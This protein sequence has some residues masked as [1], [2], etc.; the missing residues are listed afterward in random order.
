[1][2]GEKQA[3]PSSRSSQTS[4]QTAVRSP[5]GQA[6][7]G[8]QDALAR[9]RRR[10]DQTR[11][12]LVIERIT[13]AFWPV[14]SIAFLAFALIRLELIGILPE[15]LRLLVLLALVAGFGWAAVRGV[16]SFRW[17]G[18]G[19]AVRRLDDELPG[20][21][22]SSL[23][24]RQELGQDDPAA[25]AVWQIHM[26][27]IAA[28]ADRARARFPDI[29]LTARDPRALRYGALVLFLAALVFGQGSVREQLDPRAVLPPA[30]ADETGPVLEAWASPPAYTGRPVVY[31]SELDANSLEVPVGSTV[32]LRLYGGSEAPALEEAVSGGASPAALTGEP[33]LAEA[34][35]TVTRN[36]QVTISDEGTTLGDWAFT[37]T[38]DAP[39]V[40][41]LVEP[42]ERTSEGAA[43]FVYSGADDYG[44][45]AAF[46]R[47]TLDLERIERAHGLVA[48]PEARE[49]IEFDLALPRTGVAKDFEEREIIDLSEHPWAGL[50][51]KVVLHARDAAGQ[52]TVSEP[53]EVVLPGRRFY[54]PLARALVE[55]RRDLLWSLEN[56]TRVSQ[57]LK[58]ITH[59]PDD[60]FDNTKAYLATR[61]AI[62]RLDYAREGNAVAERRPE[63]SDMLWHAAL[64]VEDGDLS[65]ALERLRRAQDRLSQALE[66]PDS[67][68]EEIAGLMEEMQQ[69]MQDYLQEMMRQ[70][71]QN[72]EQNPQDQDQA[73]A[74]PNMSMQDL[75]EMLDRMNEMMQ[76]GQRAEAQELLQ[77]L[78]RLMEN[79]Q[80]TM[81]NGQPQPG[82]GEQMMQGLQDLM[83][84]QQ[85][86]GDQ[87]FEELQ[88][89]FGQQGQLGQQGQQG[90]QG[91]EGQQGQ[92]QQQ[93][94]GSGALG[95]Q[96]EA[97]RQLLEELRRGMPQGGMPG[98]NGQ[99]PG[100][101]ARRSLEQA[102]R[103]MG[104]ARDSLEN[105]D[106]GSAVDDQA[107]ALDNLREGMR[108][109]D[110]AMR[111]QA[112]NQPGSPGGP[113]RAENAPGEPRDPLGRPTG[114]QGDIEGNDVQI[115]GTEAWK[116]SRQ[117]QDEI[118][119]RA[120][121]QDR[122]EPELDYLRRLLDRF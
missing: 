15:W 101:Q 26:A 36:G 40:I 62:R 19:D 68:D 87:T 88:R 69:A 66:D 37:V 4:G 41:A 8:A 121:E 97:L 76:N 28:Q 39:P 17:P 45:T 108:S 14:W 119:R 57:L 54:E 12:A 114:S 53:Y 92:G 2:K 110:E 31:L 95:R 29:N 109:L 91:Q 103:D 48:E 83:R 77:Q 112:Q 13:Q 56:T 65:S 16:R 34:E 24:D 59:R 1:M 10:I 90:Q 32:T 115:P 33:G 9:L 96:Q 63:V 30:A 38:P 23:G 102:E 71:L 22:V 85:E 52:E 107:Q 104:S 18:R 113:E 73:Q 111:Q 116:R 44:I 11:A 99:D 20:R 105:G 47:V 6:L 25:R 98:Q 78:Q 118:R 67:S 120:G 117:L 61:T 70:A 80:M 21:P 79:L 49:P 27:R 74:E 43:Q 3:T 84:E 51:V 58:A 64:L 46:A 86:L 122:P 100:E 50:P 81:R 93:G 89:Q 5:A 94:D 60:I 35:F 7:T 42:P 72:Q 75:Q 106:P 55:Q 82:Q